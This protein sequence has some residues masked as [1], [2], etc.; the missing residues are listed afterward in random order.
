[1]NL[2][3]LDINP[4]YIDILARVS[5]FEPS[6]THKVR[7]RIVAHVAVS[8]REKPASEPAITQSKI[9]GAGFLS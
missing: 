2:R 7:P 3:S 8:H 6:K 4:L 9:L 5:G 1:M